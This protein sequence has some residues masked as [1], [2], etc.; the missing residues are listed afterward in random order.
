M[1]KKYIFHHF[2]TAQKR[3]LLEKNY[4]KFQPGILLDVLALN[5]INMGKILL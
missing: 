1:Q 3:H 2:F 4:S 5:T